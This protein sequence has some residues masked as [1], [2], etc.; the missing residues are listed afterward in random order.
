MEG[1]E[2]AGRFARQVAARVCRVSTV[3]P[4]FLLRGFENF[5][6]VPQQRIPLVS[7][8]FLK[9]KLFDRDDFLL[10]KISTTVIEWIFFNERIKS[11]ENAINDKIIFKLIRIL[12]EF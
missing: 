11:Q 4:F 6:D 5:L 12:T 1:S 9:T 3:F 2:E 10:I 7:R 8:C